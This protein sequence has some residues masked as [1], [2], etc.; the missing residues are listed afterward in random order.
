MLARAA[1][2]AAITAVD[3]AASMVAL[4]RTAVRDSRLDDRVTVVQGMLGDLPLE[5][6]AHS[7]R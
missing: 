7:M 3:G 5:T 6:Q 4:A 1:P 2:G